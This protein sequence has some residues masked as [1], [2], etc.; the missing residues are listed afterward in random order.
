MSSRSTTFRRV[1]RDVE[2]SYQARGIHRV[3]SHSPVG[4]DNLFNLAEPTD[5]AESSYE[6][7]NMNANETDSNETFNEPEDERLPAITIDGS[8]DQEQDDSENGEDNAATPETCEAAVEVGQKMLTWHLQ[9]NISEQATY[10]LLCFFK[11]H[12]S[13]HLPKNIKTLKLCSRPSE[14][15][16]E[17]IGSNVGLKSM[18]QCI[19]SKIDELEDMTNHYQLQFGID[20][21]PL[22]KGSRS[23][24]WPILMKIKS[25]LLVL[26]V[27]VY[28]GTG[29]P[30]NVHDYMK[31]FVT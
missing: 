3:R 23:E 25:F 14:V 16:V 18:L 9:Y 10:D 30:K 27:T 20:G 12:Y 5:A 17:R 13:P 15:T 2:R 11:E 28:H 21:I 19:L 4:T 22:T 7:M 31:D 6:S 24:L 26:P 8:T 1:R 29:K